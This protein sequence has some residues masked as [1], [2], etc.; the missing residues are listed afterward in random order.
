LGTVTSGPV[1]LPLCY[2]FLNREIVGARTLSAHR[3]AVPA[4]TAPLV[5]TPAFNN[6]RLI[7]PLP[8]EADGRSARLGRCERSLHARRGGVDPGR[9]AVT[10]TISVEA[11]V[12]L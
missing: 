9:R 6:E 12:Q 1:T 5:P 3:R 11:H 4:P 7:T 8:P 2:R 10:S